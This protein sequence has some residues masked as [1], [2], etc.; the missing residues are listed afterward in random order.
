M[1]IGMRSVMQLTRWSTRS[2]SAHWNVGFIAARYR[3]VMCEY[4]LASNP[5]Y[6]NDALGQR[7][8]THRIA[9][10][11]ARKRETSKSRLFAPIFFGSSA[12]RQQW[13]HFP[14]QEANGMFKRINQPSTGAGRLVL[15]PLNRFFQL[16]CSLPADTNLR[17]RSYEIRFRM[18]EI[19]PDATSSVV[20]PPY[21]S[22]IQRNEGL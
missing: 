2:P 14:A 11:R 1:R 13:R 6:G 7:R 3:S 4:G 12:H 18:S 15:I 21:K 16:P 22:L 19:T 17:R 8:Y 9:E 10:L 5:V 20:L